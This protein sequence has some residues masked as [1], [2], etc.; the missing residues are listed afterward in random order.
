MTS[1]SIKSVFKS[2]RSQMV[3][4][5]V[6][7][8]VP[9]RAVLALLGPSGCGKTT[10]LRL[11][12]GFERADSGEI[13]LGG[14][15]VEGSGRAVPPEKRRVGY[16]PQEG[17]LF[18]HL[19]LADNIA[20]GLP[21][22]ERKGSRAR[23][24]LDLIGLTPL[25]G[26]YPHQI[27]GG[28]QQRIALARALAPEPS[29][30]LLDEPFNA[31]DL[32][33]RRD[34][35]KD[36]IALLRQTGTTAIFVTHDPAEAFAAAD[37]VAVMQNGH[38]AQCAAPEA[39]YRTPANQAIARLSG[40][41]IFIEGT[42]HRDAIATPLGMLPLLRHNNGATRATAMLRPEQIVLGNDTGSRE[43]TVVDRHFRGD[44]TMLT[45]ACDG[46][47]M[48]I[49]APNYTGEQT[50]HLRVLGGCVAFPE[51]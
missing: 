3:L 27:S 28:E 18:P 47:R 14:N 34:M 35:S 49:R 29:L 20:Y 48:K 36:V 33:L 12:A 4:R 21:R 11:I 2:F 46:I 41:A 42:V 44:H 17:S 39:I 16:V 5:K 6:S 40:A 26:R 22:R 38:I 50:V 31:L 25:A 37:L 1:V 7:L 30:I 45:V 19:T 8:E 9:D 51:N 43:A 32:D 10:L 23:E 13:V 15:L 24:M